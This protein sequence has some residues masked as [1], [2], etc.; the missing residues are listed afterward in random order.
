MDVPLIRT[1]EDH[2]RVLREIEALWMAGAG[3]PE[4]DGLDVLVASA[5][6]YEEQRWPTDCLGWQRACELNAQ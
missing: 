4:G 6:R 3:T 5:E 2:R 1:D